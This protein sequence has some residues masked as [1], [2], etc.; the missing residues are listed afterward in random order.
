MDE[1]TAARDAVVIE[2]TFDAPVRHIW[3]MWTV[4]EHF[5][6]WYGPD[7]VTVLVCELDVRVGGRRL[8]RMDMPSPDGPRRMWFAGEF[9][10]VL[11]NER[12]VYT[13]FPSDEDGTPLA[14]TD[15]HG[16]TEVTEVRVDLA[17]VAGHTRI[18]MTHAGIPSDSPGATGWAMAL[19]KL[20]HLLGD[21]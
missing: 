19:D 9:L 18:V 7:G 13:D 10:D 16:L 4:P 5:A 14:G 8:I 21:A 3:Q 11:D 2:R 15:A 17:D 12:L 1:Q 6:A 20:A